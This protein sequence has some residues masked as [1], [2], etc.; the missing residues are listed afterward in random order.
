M[1]SL[2]FQPQGPEKLLDAVESSLGAWYMCS[3]GVNS[4]VVVNDMCT[5]LQAYWNIATKRLVDNVCMTMEQDFFSRLVTRAEE[6]L[7]LISS[8]VSSYIVDC[9]LLLL[10]ARTDIRTH[11]C[12]HIPREG[13]RKKRLISSS[14]PPFTL[15]LLR[16]RV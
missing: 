9:C 16:S 10:I 11:A 8:R 6:E 1:P 15:L 14:S 4:T 7:F 2:S 13:R 12:I 5:L 3:H